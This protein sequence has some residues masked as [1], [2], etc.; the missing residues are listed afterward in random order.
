MS[1]KQSDTD[2]TQA[3]WARFRF[4]VIGTLLA[5]PPENGDLQKTLT[6]LAAKQWIH[7]ITGE[8]KRFAKST[9]E[10]WLYQATKENDPVHALRTKQRTDAGKS[11]QL[12][13]HLKQII[14]QQY[15]EHPSWSYQLHVDNLK[16]LVKQSPELKPMPSYNTV[17]RYMKANNLC[18]ARRLKRRDTQGAI[19]AALRLE[20]L[21]VRSF[22]MEH[23]H[24]LW[25]LDFH[26]GSRRILGQDGQW[27]KPLLLAI[28]DDRSRLAFPLRKYLITTRIVY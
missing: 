16:V 12:S 28:M 14:Q 3:K 27:H 23:V 24:A 6:E 9:I 18:K 20:R 25:H 1:N 13:A 21:E 15:K 2:T 22:E 11:R 4:S 17:R 10:R 7:P 26:H 19:S 5:A 8:S